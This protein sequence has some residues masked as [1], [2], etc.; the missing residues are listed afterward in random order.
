MASATLAD[1][2]DHVRVAKVRY[3]LREQDQRLLNCCG[4]QD[5]P[6]TVF[7]MSSNI[8]LRDLLRGR[9]E[10]QSLDRSYR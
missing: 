4:A 5:E 3:G 9:R 7:A 1:A 10:M 6:M 8:G 2:D